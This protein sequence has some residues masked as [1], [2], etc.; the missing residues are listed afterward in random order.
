MKCKTYVSLNF[1]KKLGN[2][3]KVVKSLVNTDKE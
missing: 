2:M 3:G 1:D